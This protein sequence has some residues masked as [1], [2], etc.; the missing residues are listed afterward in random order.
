M[1]VNEQVKQFPTD[2]VTPPLEKIEEEEKIERYDPEQDHM[3]K[4]FAMF[5]HINYAVANPEISVA[6][7]LLA[8]LKMVP[9]NDPRLCPMMAVGIK[10]HQHILMYNPKWVEEVS[11]AEVTATLVHEAYHVMLRDI[12]RFLRRMAMFPDH[13]KGSAHK[14]LNVAIDAANNDLIRERMPHMKY[15][16]TGYWVLPENTSLPGKQPSEHYFEI[17]LTRARKAAKE[18]GASLQK[19]IQAV[20]SNPDASDK[21]K[22]LAQAAQALLDKN[23]HDWAKESQTSPNEGPKSFQD[24]SPDE[25]EALASTLDEEAKK[26]TVRALKTHQKRHG[27]LPGHYRDVLDDLLVEAEIPWTT[28]LRQLVAARVSAHKHKT[29]VKFHNN[30][31]VYAEEDEDGNIVPKEF[32]LPVFPGIEVDR[33]FVIMF[34]IDTSGSMSREDVEEGL[35]EL[36]GLIRTDPNVHVIVVQADTQI[37]NVSIL[38]PE[39]PLEDYMKKVGIAGRGG[40]DFNKP[41]QLAQ[42]VVGKREYPPVGAKNQEAVAQLLHDYDNIDLMVYHTDGYAPAPQFDVEPDCPTIWCL[43]ENN[44]TIP[45]MGASIFGTVIER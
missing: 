38:N 36:Q 34:A 6:A 39:Q 31:Y 3:S 14:I 42:Y 37:S 35:A 1:R 45:G 30:Q 9:V 10:N 40:T 24:M 18:A 28:F 8:R 26:H 17:L 11:F 22:Q 29:P 13:Q 12:P 7:R 44:R 5:T 33:T 27:T 21:E 19:F 16:T 41:F 15:G 43:P 20:Q 25:L 4:L 32:P 23:A 2:S